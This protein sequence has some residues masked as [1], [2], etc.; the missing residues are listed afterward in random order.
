MVLKRV[1]VDAALGLVALTDNPHRYGRILPCAGQRLP[2]PD[3]SCYE[4]DVSHVISE[5]K[6]LAIHYLNLLSERVF[7]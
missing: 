3:L 6:I 7:F 5:S 2:L 1:G 4:M